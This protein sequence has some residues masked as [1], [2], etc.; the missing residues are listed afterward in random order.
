M[1]ISRVMYDGNRLMYLFEGYTKEQ[2]LLIMR[3][4]NEIGLDIEETKA[5]HLTPPEV[6]PKSA[7]T[8]ISEILQQEGTTHG[9]QE[10]VAE[11]RRQTLSAG[12]QPPKFMQNAMKAE[13]GQETAKEAERHAAQPDAERM[14]ASKQTVSDNVATKPQSKT[15]NTSMSQEQSA[16]KPVQTQQPTTSKAPAQNA[17]PAAKTTDRVTPKSVETEQAKTPEPQTPAAADRKV[18][19]QEPV[20]TG[21]SL[22]SQATA[23][24][25]AKAQRPA[26]K[27]AVPDVSAMSKAELRNFFATTDRMALQKVLL[28]RGEFPNR[29]IFLGRASEQQMREYAKL[30][31]SA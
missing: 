26:A 18:M 29:G 20:N 7:K 24:P 11:K 31:L 10:K 27:T 2:I 25:E 9:R 12:I 5:P 15:A 14:S 8:A 28:A 6:K 30:V 17:I 1:G 22:P 16:A 4:M 13:A 23:E 3:R 21:S 19:P